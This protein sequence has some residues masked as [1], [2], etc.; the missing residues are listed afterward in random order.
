[1][2]G[3]RY[4]P[5]DWTAYTTRTASKPRDAIFTKSRI[6]AD[7]DP[8]TI[9]GGI[10]ESRDSDANPNSTPL[11]IFFDVTGSMGSMP[12]RLVKHGLGVLFENIYKFKPI[13]DPHILIGAIGDMA[14]DS[15]P[16][17]VSQYEAE[18]GPLTSQTEKIFLEGHGGGNGSE[19]YNGPWYW[20]ARHTVH[21]AWEKRSKKGY[22]ITIG[23]ENPPEAM[24][25]EWLKRFIGDDV[26]AEI[27]AEEALEMARKTY[28]CF[29]VRVMQGGGYYHAYDEEWKNLMG[30]KYLIML[31]DIEK[32]AEVVAAAIRVHE[33]ESVDTVVKSFSGSTALTVQN[34]VKHLTTKK[35]GK[36]GVMRV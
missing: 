13:S 14:Y 32:L 15:A 18:I 31:D 24:Q 3:G 12:E 11:A 35:G 25:K 36:G 29:H 16:L 21:D 30:E 6:D 5:K 8:K 7:L 1:M 22:L 33:G 34:A 28:H 23:D 27:S 26:E 19:S 20:A 4:D 17:Q 2:G 9:K 10:R